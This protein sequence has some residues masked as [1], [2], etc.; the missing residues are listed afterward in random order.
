MSSLKILI[1]DDS[2]S[3]RFAV[4]RLLKAHA[5]DICEA[6]SAAEALDKIRAERP[7]AVF[8]DHVMPDRDG[9][10]ALVDIRG[11][12][13]FGSLPVY[14]CSSHDSEDFLQQARQRGATGVLPKPPD[15]QQMGRIVQALRNDNASPTAAAAAAPAPAAAPPPP[16]QPARPIGLETITAPHE[17]MTTRIQPHAGPAR[18]VTTGG[19]TAAYKALSERVTRLEQSFSTIAATLRQAVD[20]L[21]AIENAAPPEAASRDADALLDA[22]IAALSELR[23]RQR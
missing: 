18:S 2:R 11:S 22:L 23:E 15:P 13:G 14:I 7:D 9:L 19:S 4:G 3:A 12:D 17:A 10:E 1:V 6:S 5:V 20:R 16:A 21:D 8:M